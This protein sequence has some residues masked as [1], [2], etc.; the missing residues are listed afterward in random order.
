MGLIGDGAEACVAVSFI[1]G[2]V[3]FEPDDPALS[4]EGEDVR[5]DPIEE[6]T[7]VANDDGAA[8][9]VLESLFE[10]THGVD[11]EVIGRLVEEE[12]VGARFES[13]GE[14]DAVALPS[15]EGTDPLLLIRS[16][17]IEAGDIGAGV[18]LSIAE[19]K[20]LL[21]IGDLL[22][23][24]GIGAKGIAALIDIGEP[25]GLTDAKVAV[26]GGLLTGDQAEEGRLAG[27][28]GT[29][30][31]DDA[32]GGEAKTEL[33]EEE[34]FAIRPVGLGDVVGL[35]DQVSEARSGRDIEFQLGGLFVDLLGKQRFIRLEAGLALGLAGL[36]SHPD[37]FEFAL[38]GLLS[39]ALCL[40]LPP[41][42]LLLLVEPRGVVSPPGDSLPPV[43]FQ[44][45][46]GDIVEK[47]AVVGDGDDRS[48]ILLEVMFEPSDSLRVEVVGWFVE[49]E[50]LGL[51]EE[52]AAESD[53][54]PFAPG[55]KLDWSLG[56]GQRR[57]S[58]A[59]SRRLSRSHPP[60]ASSFSWTSP[61]R[62]SSA[63]ISSSDMGSAKRPLI[64]SYSRSRSTTGCTPSST[65]SR[66]VLVLSSTGSCSRSPMAYPGERTTSPWYSRSSPAMIRRRLL[67]PDPLRPRT[68]I[69]AP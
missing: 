30:D 48:R 47:V 54:A 57:A 18:D 36:G 14:V 55:E 62:S 21:S 39:L 49:E 20:G 24:G 8:G 17:E 45:P 59:I 12:D 5:R 68:P 27:P 52:K 13:L 28:I 53:A 4:F 56:G 38:E 69:L 15:G 29:D 58:M 46:A 25:D 10:R 50:D 7:V 51:F 40:L 32:S 63:V 1:G 2:V 9:E 11:I 6:P 61:C 44:N 33:L 67:F 26:V 19:E 37:P 23:D 43:E 64:S 3:A 35:D 34:L 65:T 60:S 16:R 41:Q 22:P 66:T 42:A 31:A